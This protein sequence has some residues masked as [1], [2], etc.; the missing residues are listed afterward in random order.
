MNEIEVKILDVDVASTVQR[1]L[2]LGAKKTF[3]GAIAA[4]YFNFPQRPL[5]YPLRLRKKGDLVELCY[6]KPI[7]LVGAK[8]MAEY[9]THVESYDATREL[10]LAMGM[11]DISAQGMT[12]HRT[13]YRLGDA[14]YEF[15]TFPGLPTLLEVE[16]NSMP[17][18]ERAVETIGYTMADTRPWSGKDVIEHY[19][20]RG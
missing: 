6:K 17:V 15:D 16:A 3:E 13:S 7:S 1:L 8:S 11:V 19:A 9:E 18:L 2:D 20:K 12:K 14:L 5:E 10:L 4:S